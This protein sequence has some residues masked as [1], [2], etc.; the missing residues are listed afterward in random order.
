MVCGGFSC[1]KNALIA[2]NSLYIIV[3]LILIIVPS[4]AKSGSYVSSLYI[5]G[6]IIACGIFLFIVAVAGLIGAIKHHQVCLFFYMLILFLVFLIQFSVS[7]AALACGEEQ[8]EKLVR[9]SWEHS[10]NDTK[11]DIQQS[12]CC[13]GFDKNDTSHP[14]CPKAQKNEVKCAD[15]FCQQ[16]MDEGYAQGLKISG[17]VGL[18]FSL[19]EFVGC[20]VTYR[21]RNQKDPRANPNAFL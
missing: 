4:L 17:A 11:T 10:S 14:T 15:Q 13:C 7:I 8:R 3:A 9:L 19:T 12:F 6:G 5:I 18:F 20:V 16:K 2:L 21:Y 1:S